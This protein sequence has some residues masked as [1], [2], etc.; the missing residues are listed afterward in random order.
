MWSQ[1]EISWALAAVLLAAQDAAG[2]ATVTSTR[3]I[4]L[5]TARLPDAFEV[6][7]DFPSV[8][9][10][11]AF[12][13]GYNN[14]FSD[15][16]VASL[17]SRMAAPPVIRIGGTSG[18]K[19][20]FNPGQAEPAHCI[21]TDKPCNSAARFI[22]GPTYFDAFKYFFKSAHFS[23]QAPLGDGEPNGTNI[24]AYVKGAYDA[25]GD[26]AR[27]NAVA[28]GNEVNWY[29]EKQYD[30]AEYVA[31]AQVAKDAITSAVELGS[32][33]IWEILDTAS[34]HAST[35]NAP[36]TVEGVFDAGIN[37]DGKVKYVAEHY[38]QFDGKTHGIRDHLLNHA[39]LKNKLANYFPSIRAT[40]NT[41]GAKFI[42]SETGGPLGVSEEVQTF[43]A[44][45]LWSVNFQLYAM[46]RNVSRVTGVQRPEA[47][48]SLWIPTDGLAVPGPRVQ[49][50]Y[51]ALPFVADFVGKTAAGGP[52]GVVNIDLESPVLS[53]YAMFEGQTLARV[54]VVNLREYAG[55]A[56]RNAVKVRLENLGAAV[57]EVQV[58]RLHADAG[59]AAGGFDVNEK[60]ITWA[61]QQWSYKVDGGEGHGTVRMT[62]LE[63]TGGVAELV[64]PDTEAVIVYVK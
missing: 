25:L 53:A 33:P 31:D 32:D 20:N 10:E 39:A 29:H 34:G 16:L 36:Y 6:P 14:T 43:F 56:T 50:P 57:S 30:A 63:V 38:Y 60:N 64:I 15:K 62:T 42:L 23:I 13:P 49:A 45:T 19:I 58:G 47:K 35:G 7:A 2:Q 48:R 55:G 44:N 5:P 61:G 4:P 27:I 17:A 54:A 1:T 59:T 21:E 8:G 26:A 9:F 51:Y 11:T 3:A 28:I 22:L 24:I 18:D 37:Q 46:S 41:D 40:R 52:R 12:L